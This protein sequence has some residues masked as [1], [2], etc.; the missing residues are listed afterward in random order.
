MLGETI[1]VSLLQNIIL[2]DKTLDDKEKDLLCNYILLEE[3]K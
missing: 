3:K 1:N 2:N